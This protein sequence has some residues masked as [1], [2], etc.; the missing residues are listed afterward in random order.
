[1]PNFTGTVKTVTGGNTEKEGARKD[2]GFITLRTIDYSPSG[3][4]S[5]AL[6][7]ADV[8]VHASKIQGRSSV[9]DGMRLQFDWVS[10]PKGPKVSE[11]IVI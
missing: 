10:S 8:F 4:R 11:A 3:D 6:P 9:W 1:M 7:P 2:F 5:L